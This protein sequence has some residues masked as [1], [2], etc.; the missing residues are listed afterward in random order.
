MMM[1]L[2]RFCASYSRGAGP[3]GSGRR[4]DSV[5]VLEASKRVNE[6]P[7]ELATR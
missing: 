7:T 1:H 2:G 5:L 6:S 3:C 4:K